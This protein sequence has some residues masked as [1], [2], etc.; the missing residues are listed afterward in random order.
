M[1]IGALCCLREFSTPLSDATLY[2]DFTHLFYGLCFT[3]MGEGGPTH[4]ALLNRV[5]SMT[6]R[7]INFPPLTEFFNLS[8]IV[9]VLMHLPCSTVTF[10]A[11]A[12]N[13]YRYISCP[14]PA[15]SLD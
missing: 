10:K 15:D 6:I 13:C 11:A 5:E 3:G 7:L 8:N 12:I 4:K 1:K 2:R 9:V 14:L